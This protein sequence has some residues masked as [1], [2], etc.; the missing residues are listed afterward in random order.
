MGISYIVYR[1]FQSISY[2]CATKSHKSVKTIIWD[3]DFN[4]E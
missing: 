3:T 2:K 4:K 1:F